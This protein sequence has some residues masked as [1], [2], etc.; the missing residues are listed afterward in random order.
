MRRDTSRSLI[1][2]GQVE[3]WTVTPLPRVMNPT[4]GSPGMGWQHLAN[5]TSRSPTPLTRTPPVRGGTPGGAAVG[6][7]GWG[8]QATPRPI[9]EGCA[10]V[11]PYPTAAG[12]SSARLEV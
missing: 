11:G 10:P 5:R 8:A 2:V 4:M 3:R 6:G 12:Q 1:T 7:A 9:A